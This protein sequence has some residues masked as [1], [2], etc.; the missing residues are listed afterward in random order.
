[1]STMYL[2]QGGNNNLRTFQPTAVSLCAQ[3]PGGKRQARRRR[4]GVD[5]PREDP[6]KPPEASS[7]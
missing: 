7:Q 5:S 4:R 2:L 1:M 3:H 6:G